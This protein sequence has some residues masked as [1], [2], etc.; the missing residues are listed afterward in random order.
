MELAN[1][2]AVEVARHGLHRMLQDRSAIGGFSISAVSDRLAA[3]LHWCKEMT[4]DSQ[5]YYPA[6]NHR[7]PINQRHQRTRNETDGL[8]RLLLDIELSIEPVESDVESTSG[9]EQ[10]S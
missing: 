7:R 6:H 10:E 1:Q 5:S 2:A 4:S 8:Q 9:F 3:R